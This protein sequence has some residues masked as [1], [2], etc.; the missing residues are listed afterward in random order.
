MPGGHTETP[1]I[2]SV[3]EMASVIWRRSLVTKTCSGDWYVIICKSVFCDFKQKGNKQII[4]IIFSLNF[5][6]IQND[7]SR[8]LFNLSYTVLFG[9]TFLI[10]LHKDQLFELF[11]H[12]IGFIL[13]TS[14]NV[15]IQNTNDEKLSGSKIND[16]DVRAMKALYVTCVSG[17]LAAFVFRGKV[18]KRILIVMSIMPIIIL[19]LELPVT[20][21]NY[22]NYL[23]N[24]MLL[25]Y[26]I[27]PLCFAARILKLAF[28]YLIEEVR[29]EG[30]CMS[31]LKYLVHSLFLQ[32][33]L[34]L[35]WLASF[36][37]NV[38]YYLTL[39]LIADANV[40]RL[41]WITIL[42]LCIGECCKTYIGLLATSVALSYASYYIRHMLIIF[43][44]GERMDHI[45]DIGYAILDSMIMFL[46]SV[47]SGIIDMKVTINHQYLLDKAFTLRLIFLYS[48]TL[49]LSNTY[50]L[51]NL[52]I[53]TFGASPVTK[54]FQHIK[55]LGLYS[56]IL[57]FLLCTLHVVNQLISD[58]MVTYPVLI[59]GFSTIVQIFCSMLTYFIFMYDAIYCVENIDDRI[60]YLR[61]SVE[62][63]DYLGSV[64]IACGGLWLLK[65]NGFSWIQTP[66]LILQLCCLWDRFQNGLKTLVLRRDARKKIDSIP[67]A[68][69]KKLGEYDDVC[70][71]CHQNMSSAKITPC[72]HLYHRECL[73]K[74]INLKDS[75]PLCSYQLTFQTSPS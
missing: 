45:N 31:A 23:T 48:A 42:F 52:K 9:A 7:R 26:L 34:L 68:T 20:I 61:S 13:L 75:C 24:A 10:S 63:L 65:T 53:L 54:V 30:T 29:R 55:A 38:F 46:M 28:S 5:S 43:L 25:C 39:I 66:M 11:E 44:C 15:N 56:I 49:F 14:Y 27:Y 69:R 60:F 4:V 1:S 64:I 70:P 16:I 33:Q 2:L 32:H 8:K 22:V 57:V 17:L 58:V 74:W 35:F 62:V 47:E 59:I 71:I 21:I 41:N 51:L 40:M 12:I 37:F 67:T 50:Q 3:G 19:C 36:T 6:S 73:Q 72:G 18:I